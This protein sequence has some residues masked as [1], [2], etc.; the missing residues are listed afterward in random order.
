MSHQ[1]VYHDFVSFVSL[2][3]NAEFKRITTM[4]LQSRFLSQLDM[5]SH[6]LLKL[7]NKRGGQIG[8]RL[9]S[10]LTCMTEVREFENFEIVLIG[11]HIEFEQEFFLQ[12][13]FLP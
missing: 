8:K 7:F 13:F 12:I 11:V 3:I 6:K 4:P 1:F 9:Q 10:I 2:Q 5:L